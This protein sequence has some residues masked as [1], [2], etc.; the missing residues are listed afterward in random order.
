[1]A[2]ILFCGLAA[3]AQQEPAEPPEEDEALAAKEYAF[4]PL[5][6]EKELKIGEFYWKKGSWKAAAGRFREATLWNPGFAPA[7]LRLGEAEE[8]LRNH[9]AARAAYAKFLELEPKD[10]RAPEI[11][12]RMEAASRSTPRSQ[13]GNKST[14]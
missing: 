12:R 7:W 13:S 8:K 2:L 9:D 5:Q 1:L 6:A 4:N 10:K 11:R 14:H 3:F